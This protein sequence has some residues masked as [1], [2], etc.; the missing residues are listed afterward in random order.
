MGAGCRIRG[1]LLATGA[2]LPV[3]IGHRGGPFWANQDAAAW[4]I[5]KGRPLLGKAALDAT[6]REFT[7]E[8]CADAIVPGDRWHRLVLAQGN[9]SE[10]REG[11]SLCSMCWL[12]LWRLAGNVVAMTNSIRR[13][14]IVTG[15]VQGVGFRWSARIQAQRLGVVG[16]VVNRTDGTVEVEAEGTADAVERMLQWLRHGPT[17]TS[18]E[19]T[20]VAELK[21]AG[22]EGFDIR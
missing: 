4:S 8:I 21:P 2:L 19:S 14:V 16:Y 3:R 10:G 18:V 22:D 7:E 11:G 5:P 20:E 15:Q 12:H 9:E 1:G 17:G 13:H 6:H